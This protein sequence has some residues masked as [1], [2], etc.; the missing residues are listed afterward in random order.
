MAVTSNDRQHWQ[1]RATNRWP[2][3]TLL[4]PTTRL[5]C[6]LSTSLF[7][8]L[9]WHTPFSIC[10]STLQLDLLYAPFSRFRS[11][12]ITIILI[13]DYFFL[14][15]L[16]PFHFKLDL[17]TTDRL[18]LQGIFSLLFRSFIE[19]SV[20]FTKWWHFPSVISLH[21]FDRYTFHVRC[22]WI[23]IPLIFSFSFFSSI[24]SP[25]CRKFISILAS[26]SPVMCNVSGRVGVGVGVGVGT[27]VSVSL[28]ASALSYRWLV[29]RRTKAVEYVGTRRDHWEFNPSTL[30]N[31]RSHLLITVASL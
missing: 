20:L 11:Y 4:L 21:I 25:C 8:P 9:L 5:S 10:S 26:V 13:K 19:V 17:E 3:A 31:L 2:T 30:F 14:P 29:S 28:S 22:F 6:F 16:S 23:H 18:F 7:N 12:F 15:F 24:V 1:S 27:S